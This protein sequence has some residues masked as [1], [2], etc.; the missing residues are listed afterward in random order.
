MFL[1][2]SDS[3]SVKWVDTTEQDVAVI[4]DCVLGRI[5]QMRVEAMPKGYMFCEEFRI[6][7]AS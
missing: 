2:S 6:F 3:L 1:E 4:A 5:L 7:V